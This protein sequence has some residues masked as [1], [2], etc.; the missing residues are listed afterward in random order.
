MTPVFGNGLIRKNPGPNLFL[1]MHM[2]R[3][4]NTGGFKLPAGHL[5]SFRGHDSESTK[6]Q[7]LTLLGV[8][9]LRIR[10]GQAVDGRKIVIR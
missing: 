10:S 4:G 9:L 3:Y 8:F 1:T 6:I 7:L 5:K 2:V